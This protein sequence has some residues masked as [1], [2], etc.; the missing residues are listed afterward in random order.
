MNTAHSSHTFLIENHS[1]FTLDW[2]GRINSRHDWIILLLARKI[3]I[4][5]ML[6]LRAKAAKNIWKTP[7]IFIDSSIYICF[8]SSFFTSITDAHNSTFSSHLC[9]LSDRCVRLPALWVRFVD[10][11]RALY[12][13]ERCSRWLAELSV[14]RSLRS[15]RVYIAENTDIG[16]SRRAGGT[17]KNTIWFPNA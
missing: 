11:D 1:P 6:L 5:S 13:S 12:T 4:C 8:F 3:L 16:G 17:Y 2:V 14:G 7:L 15:R 10:I 9:L